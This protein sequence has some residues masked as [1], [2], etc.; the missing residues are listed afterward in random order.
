VIAT[1]ATAL[2]H[3]W[4]YAGWVVL[5]LRL[6]I[7]LVIL[8]CVGSIG[9]CLVLVKPWRWIVA[10][11]TFIVSTTVLLTALVIIF[12]GI[13]GYPVFVIERFFTFP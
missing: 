12:N 11:A 10:A 8:A 2:D 6:L 1:A 4:H 9:V 7:F 13:A 3:S 5:D